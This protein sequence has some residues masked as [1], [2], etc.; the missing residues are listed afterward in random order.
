MPKPL[1][2]W[3]AS[4][5]AN[6]TAALPAILLV[7]GICSAA[8]FYTAIDL[9]DLPGGLPL[10][11]AAGLNNA[12]QVTG[13]SN[14]TRGASAYLWDN[15]VLID[16]LAGTGSTFS[17]GRDIN[18]HG[19]VI[20]N[21]GATPFLWDD[22]T[23]TPLTDLNGN[24]FAINNS[25]QIVGFVIADTAGVPANRAF[26]WE[27]GQ[28]SLLP[29]L[30]QS[31]QSIAFD[32]NEAGQIV[33][34]DQS[35][36]LLWDTGTVIALPKLAIG[37]DNEAFGINDLSQAVGRSDGQAVLWEGQAVSG[38]GILEGFEASTA[39]GINNLGQ[40]VGFSGTRLGA[41]QRAFVWADESGMLDLNELVRP[42]IG[43]I[44]TD[45]PRI[46]N[47]GEIIAFSRL[48]NDIRSFLLVPIPEPAPAF[49]F[50]AGLAAL[51]A[52]RRF[53]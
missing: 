22:G 21:D 44:L 49:L 8:P 15:G 41:P 31:N 46:N 23:I 3:L 10:T 2:S 35:S 36:A 24:P 19:Q 27:G 39:T 9:G 40:I 42:S 52:R 32:I 4:L 5:V 33:G 13:T 34:G 28:L 51:A 6:S 11:N 7:P 43:R 29:L 38:L 25:S 37:G 1:L 47:N 17:N 45:A 50:A 48:P 14:A 30:P 18:D 20:G 16:L 12:R 26:L 53:H